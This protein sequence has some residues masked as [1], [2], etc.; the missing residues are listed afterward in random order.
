MSAGRLIIH[1]PAAWY[2]PAPSPV[3]EPAAPPAIVSAELYRARRATCDA[4]EHLATPAQCGCAAGLCAHPQAN[5]LHRP[6]PL[7]LA[8]TCPA[9]LWPDLP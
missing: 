3:P 9:A 4:C 2:P 5:P 7:L 6:S 1:D 8:A